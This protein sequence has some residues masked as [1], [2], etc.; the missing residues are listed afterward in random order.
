[1]D[2]NKYAFSDKTLKEFKDICKEN[3]ISGEGISDVASVCYTR[4]EFG[5]NCY[6]CECREMCNKYS[7]RLGINQIKDID[8]II[9]FDVANLWWK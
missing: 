9:I 2:N 3:K 4:Q 1:M 6:D 7:R 8:P 5:R